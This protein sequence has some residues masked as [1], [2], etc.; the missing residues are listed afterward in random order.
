MLLTAP[1]IKSKLCTAAYKSLRFNHISCPFFPVFASAVLAM[2][3]FLELVKLIKTVPSI[4]IFGYCSL[5]MEHFY[6]G[7]SHGWFFQV[8]V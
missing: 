1:R 3:Q 7:F 2:C 8:S 5:C 6:P 4:D